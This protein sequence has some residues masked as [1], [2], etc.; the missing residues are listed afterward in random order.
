VCGCW[1]V[2]ILFFFFLGVGVGVGVW[3]MWELFFGV[4]QEHN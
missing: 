1:A 3:F 4:V 2:Y